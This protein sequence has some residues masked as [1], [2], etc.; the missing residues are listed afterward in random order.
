VSNCPS[1]R[2]PMKIMYP[3]EVL[4]SVVNQK[5]TFEAHPP[6]ER[7]NDPRNPLLQPI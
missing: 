3:L 6:E 1:I 2:T 4:L 5:K 7:S